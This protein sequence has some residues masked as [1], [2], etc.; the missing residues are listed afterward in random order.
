MQ[1]TFSANAAR[2]KASYLEIEYAWHPRLVQGVYGVKV[3]KEEEG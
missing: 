3:G 1:A 2:R